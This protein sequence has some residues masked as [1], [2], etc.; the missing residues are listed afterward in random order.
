L[1]TPSKSFI[2]SGNA[3]RRRGGLFGS[4]SSARR[5]SRRC[6]FLLGLWWVLSEGRPTDWGFGIVVAAVAAS[7]ALHKEAGGNI[8]PTRLLRFVPFFL[9]QSFVAA[10]EVARLALNPR[11]RLRPSL[12]S[13]CPRLRSLEAQVFLANT[14]SLLPGTLTADIWEGKLCLHVLIADP[15]VADKVAAVEERVA[16]LFGETPTEDGHGSL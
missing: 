16:A 12:L 9:W 11:L 5:W 15:H 4:L 7:F 14:I 8:R 10:V 6:I 2:R 13:Y 3:R 1:A